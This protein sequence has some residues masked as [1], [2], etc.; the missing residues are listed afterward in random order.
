[1][2]SLVGAAAG[3]IGGAFLTAILAAP[4]ALASASTLAFGGVS[5]EDEFARRFLV[6]VFLLIAVQL[7]VSAWI[8]QQTASLVGDG[9]V[10]FWRAVGA[11]FLGGLATLVAALALLG[12]PAG[13]GSALSPGSRP[14]G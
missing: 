6:V 2:A 5:S 9:V 10:R 11:L 7:L 3:F 1:M 4:F 14:R 8:A 12:R 13:C